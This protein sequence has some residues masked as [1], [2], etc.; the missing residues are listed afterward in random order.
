MSSNNATMA[1]EVTS[2]SRDLN[3]NVGGVIDLI[4][5]QIPYLICKLPNWYSDFLDWY[6][7]YLI[8]IQTSLINMQ[9][10]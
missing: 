5:M 7:N 2:R 9:I 1:P 6:A 3:K 8:D 10:T 4:N